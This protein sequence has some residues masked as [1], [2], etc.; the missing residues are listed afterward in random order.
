M[1]M[2]SHIQARWWVGKTANKLRCSPCLRVSVVSSLGG[3]GP[4]RALQARWLSGF[5]F[6]SGWARS[7]FPVPQRVQY[8]FSISAILALTSFLIKVA[9]GG[10]WWGKR[11]V[12]REVE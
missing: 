2:G 8:F 4:L 12:P 7:Q 1:G 9:G 10:L 3:E 5:S 11:T 6:E